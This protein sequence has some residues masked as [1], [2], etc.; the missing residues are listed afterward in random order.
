MSALDKLSEH[1]GQSERIS[2]EDNASSDADT[3]SQRSISLSSDTPSPKIIPQDTPKPTEYSSAV[4][5]P[6]F[7]P[8]FSRNTALRCEQSHDTSNP[9]VTPRNDDN[10]VDSASQIMTSPSII[11]KRLSHP[12]TLDTDLSSEPDDSSLYK[13]RV[14]S[15]TSAAPSV[16]E[17]DSNAPMPALPKDRDD[18]AS[19]HSSFSGTSCKKA[20]PESLLVQ[21]TKGA[22][23]LGIALVDFDHLVCVSRSFANVPPPDF[24]SQVGPRIEYSK[25]TVFEDQ[26]LCKVLPFLALPDGAHLVRLSSAFP[27]P[28]TI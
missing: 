7:P 22:L 21:S 17:H 28:P 9:V 20:R 10:S 18:I 19:L 25:G 23:V 1:I 13:T 14:S 12:N 27:V 8:S 26:E 3:A 11:S 5:L 16:D 24:L 15:M 6:P 2:S 4:T